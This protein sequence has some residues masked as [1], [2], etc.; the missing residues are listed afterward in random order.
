MIK[1][2]YH[3]HQ[4]IVRKIAAAFGL[5]EDLSHH[6]RID[7]SPRRIIIHA[8]KHRK[9]HLRKGVH[10]WQKEHNKRVAEFHKNHASRIERGENGNGLLAKWERF[11]YSKGRSLIKTVK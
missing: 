9:V 8:T 3:W 1:H 6:H 4:A 7:G 10:Q 11:V 5:P 2:I